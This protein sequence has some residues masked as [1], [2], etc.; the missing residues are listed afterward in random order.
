MQSQLRIWPTKSMRVAD[1]GLR[2]GIL[3]SLMSADN[4]FGKGNEKNIAQ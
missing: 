4:Q 1:R 3:Y 2:E